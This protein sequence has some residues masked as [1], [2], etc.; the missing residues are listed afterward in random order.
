MKTV[1]SRIIY[2]ALALYDEDRPEFD[3][4]NPI[5]TGSWWMV[6][7]WPCTAAGR[8]HPGA[9]VCAV[10]I[11]TSNLGAPVGAMEGGPF[12]SELDSEDE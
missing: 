8:V 6:D 1:S 5:T 9:N 3:C 12:W 10:P 2:A 7:C 4:Y 11:H